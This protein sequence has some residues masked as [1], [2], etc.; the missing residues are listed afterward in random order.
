M[1]P[2]KSRPK[3]CAILTTQDSWKWEALSAAV[4]LLCQAALV[5]ILQ[6]MD[7]KPLSR[8]TAPVSL[9]AAVSILTTASKSLLLLVVAECIS[10]AKWRLF[11]KPQRLLDFDVF[12][13]ASRGPFGSLKVLL[14]RRFYLNWVFLGACITI[15]SLAIDPFAQQVLSMSQRAVPMDLDTVSISYNHYYENNATLRA[16]NNTGKLFQYDYSR[17]ART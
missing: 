2:Q 5:S 8:W 10:Q 14:K 16:G 1:I 11:T 4:C 9:N 17:V 7:Q 3:W 6:S 13:N 15:L 12:D